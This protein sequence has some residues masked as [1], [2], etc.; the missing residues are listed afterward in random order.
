MKTL[1]CI[2][3]NHFIVELSIFVALKQCRVGVD[4]IYRQ[5]GGSVDL[6]YLSAS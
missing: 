5:M 3:F 6:T 1:L 2:T 4:I